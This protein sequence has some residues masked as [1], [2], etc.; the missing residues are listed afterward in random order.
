MRKV[1]QWTFYLIMIFLF[2]EGIFRICF[3]LPEL[4]N[5]DR[6]NYIKEDS[7]LK[8]YNHLRDQHWYWQSSPDTNATFLHEMNR[9]GFRDEAWEVDKDPSRTRILFIGDSFVE[10]VMATQ[11]ETIPYGF[12][13][14]TKSEQLEVFNMGMMGSGLNSYLQLTTDAISTFKPDY[15]FFCISTN[16]LTQRPPIIPQLYLEPEYYNPYLP[17]LYQLIL[18]I[19]ENNPVS[20]RWFK[21]SKSFLPTKKSSTSPWHKNEQDLRKHTTPDMAEA[22][23]NGTYSPFRTNNLFHEEKNLKQV[24]NLGEILPFLKYFSDEFGVKTVIV[25][26]PSRNITTR[27]YYQYEMEHCLIKCADTLDLTTEKYQIH[28]ST[29]IDQSFKHKIPLIDLTSIVKGEESAGNHLYWN[30]DDHMRSKGYLL[31]GASIYDIWKTHLYIE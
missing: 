25:Y 29:L 3:P 16:D 4:S 20:F 23:I 18:L 6:I 27:Y 10:G 14:S 30:Y 17:R 13:Q 2:Q 7:N 22:M 26:I 12:W 28:R 21:Q 1:L 24:P 9:Y 5:F 31:L 8:R 11:K 19:Q 15:L